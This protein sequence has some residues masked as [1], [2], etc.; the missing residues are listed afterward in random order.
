MVTNMAPGSWDFA[1]RLKLR[2]ALETLPFTLSGVQAIFFFERN[3]LFTLIVI[4]S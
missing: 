4:H 2:L 3:A 1:L